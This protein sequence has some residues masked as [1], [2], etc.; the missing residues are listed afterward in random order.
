M[1]QTIIRRHHHV[2]RAASALVA[3]TM[4]V[5]C[6]S[7]CSWGGPSAKDAA[8]SFAQSLAG[9]DIRSVSPAAQSDLAA[10]TKGMDGLRPTVTVTA[11]EQDGDQ[12]KATLHVSWPLTT[13]QLA[14]DSS[15]RLTRQDGVWKPIWS[16]TVV[17]P[18][19]TKDARLAHQT[20][21]AKRADIT[22][23][24]GDPLMTYRPVQRIGINKPDIPAKQWPTSAAALA[25]ELDIDP[26]AYQGKVTAAGKAAFVEALVVRG[27]TT[28]DHDFAGIP[29]A[30]SIPDEAILGPTRTFATGLLGTVAPATAEQVAASKGALQGGE[31]VGQS[32]LQARYDSQLRGKPGELVVIRARATGSVPDKALYRKDATP[33]TPLKT[34][35][36]PSWQQ[37]AEQT[38]ATTTPASAIV[39]INPSNG[40]VLAAATGP[41]NATSAD[42]TLGRYAPGSTFKAVTALA[43]LRSGMTPDSMVNCTSTV[44]VDGRRFKN[45]NDFPADRVGR[46]TLRDAIAL[47]CN[48]GL[49]AE[50]ARVDGAKIRDA[51]ASLGLG[52]DYDAGLPAFFGS[53]PDPKSV[54]GL[55]ESMIGQG[56]IEASPM[57]MATVAASIQAGHT[58]RPVL[59]PDHQ[60]TTPTAPELTPAEADQLRDMLHAVVTHGSGRM[61]AGLADGA[62][63]GTA[64]YG[65]DTPP[66]TH[67]WMIAYNQQVALATMVV[68]G[69]SG[70]GTAGPL[71]EAMLR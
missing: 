60:T 27:D 21:W 48:T 65:T 30:T 58:V 44:T 66:K 67:A 18:S 46:M 35:L 24:D 8:A 57:A 47:S 4:V 1:E 41:A 12:A 54:V 34:T 50:H 7:G 71:I 64:E 43:L 68:D 33:G 55:A 56:I 11:A 45:Y 28:A 36:V 15:V 53:A 39:G 19:L 6:L 10:I 63:T 49:I 51:A 52:Q 70:S 37:L 38:L 20:T 23:A 16:P 40:H 32:G 62:K 17:H 5:S 25:K 3:T 22:D 26:K 69:N 31:L 13:G 59:L 61:L 42:A 14:Y 9:G 29:G 2:P